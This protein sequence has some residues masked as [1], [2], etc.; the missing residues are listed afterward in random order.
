MRV[1][2]LSVGMIAYCVGTEHV[3][4]LLA[5]GA[6]PPRRFQL[7][8]CAD[9]FARV[10]TLMDALG[11]PLGW[12]PSRRSAVI[13]QFADDWGHGLLPPN[14]E[15]SRFDVLLVIPHHFLHGVPLHLVRRDGEPL[16]ATHG[17]AYCSSATLLQRCFERNRARSVDPRSWIF[18]VD[19]DRA[20]SSGPEVR[21]CLSCG[22]D[23]LTDKDAQY[24]ELARAFASHFSATSEGRTRHDV[25]NALDPTRR[26]A[27]E[28][29]ILA[30]DVLCLVCHGHV[31]PVQVDRSGLLLWG[32]PGWL[33]MQNVR[34]HGDTILRVQDHP[35]AD[36]PAR[37]EPGRPSSDEHT[38]GFVPEMMTTGE[39]LVQCECDSQLVAL[40]GC[41]TGTGELSSNDDYVSL[42][43]QWL[44][45]G[46][47]SV[48]ANLW[49]ADLPALTEWARRFVERWTSLR[50]PKAIA[51]RETTREL[52][53]DRPEWR[54]QPELWG[55]V[56]LL[57]D[58]L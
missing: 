53:A 58:W 54:N 3:F 42:A 32:T 34:V 27:G 52:L 23:V 37:L 8:R 33:S 16:A 9:V 30:P 26:A 21:T 56:A 50:Q 44:K 47:P 10:D 35:F 17:I 7:A 57:G 18:P 41:S 25:K 13:G 19:G 5:D 24:L 20:P 28:D 48:I 49:E 11:Q 2:D 38:R 1:S 45:I 6:G 36:I 14:E 12:V 22:A 29:A 4:A 40:F 43:Y 46:A 15:L 55:C 31:D 51:V 39:L